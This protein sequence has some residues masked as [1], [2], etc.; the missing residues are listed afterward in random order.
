MSFVLGIIV[1]VTMLI[2]ISEAYKL[3]KFTYMVEESDYNKTLWYALISLITLGIGHP[4]F[5]SGMVI[6]FS[7]LGLAV[8]GVVMYVRIR[9]SKE[10][11]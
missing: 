11:V 6:T 7:V 5:A 8:A 10:T 1:I 2:A 3:Y 4:L 9:T